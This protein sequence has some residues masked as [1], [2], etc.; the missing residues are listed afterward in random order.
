MAVFLVSKK[1]QFL[2]AIGRQKN[3][4][5]SAHNLEEETTKGDTSQQTQNPTL[6]KIDATETAGTDVLP[7][8]Y[9]TNNAAK[10]SGIRIAIKAAANF[11]VSPVT[12][13][14]S[15]NTC[16]NVASV[17]EYQSISKRY[18]TLGGQNVNN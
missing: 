3:G 10:Y 8:T 12:A 4:R 17:S 2:I 6:C 14:S 7:R 16:I 5:R 15:R 1:G 13:R 11:T 9:S 18:A